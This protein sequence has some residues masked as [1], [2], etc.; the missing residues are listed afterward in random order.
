MRIL[1]KLWLT[2]VLTACSAASLLAQSTPII[3]DVTAQPP[4][5]TQALAPLGG[6]TF[7]LTVNGQNF[8]PFSKVFFGG[9]PLTTAFVSSIQLTATVPASLLQAPGNI[10]VTVVNTD[11][12]A[13]TPS[14]VTLSVSSSTAVGA[15]QVTISYNKNIVSLV[16]GN[17]TGGSGA[18]FTGSPVTINIDNANGQVTLNSF[19]TGNT[20]AGTFSV[21]NLTFTGVSAGSSGL[22]I[23]NP[24]L[25]DTLSHG[26]PI[27]PAQI[28]LSANSVN[29]G[30]AATVSNAINFRV[31]ER[32]DLNGDRKVSI[33]DALYSAL[34]SSGLVKPPAPISAGDL[35]LS[36]AANIGDALVLAL[37]SGRLIPNLPS[38][39]VTS[40]S[41]A[42]AVAGSNL[43]LTGTG[44]SSINA[45]NQVLFTT[46]TGTVRVTPTGAVTNISMTVTV[47]LDAV[48][49]PMQ[50][51]RVDATVATDEFPL[52]VSGTNTPLLLSSVTPF[53]RVITG[54]SVLLKG[55]GFSAAAAD[56][57]VTFR[58]TS[59][60][61]VTAAVT[62]ASTTSLT[63]ALP[64]TAAC[65]EVTVTVG[66]QTSNAR[67]ITVSGT[68]CPKK[69]TDILGGG[70]PGD[71]LALEGVGFDFQTPANNI[72]RF[73]AASGGTT[74]ATVLESGGTQLQ[75]LIPPNAASG[76]ITVTVAGTTSNTLNY[77]LSGPTLS[78]IDPAGGATGTIVN[79]TL[80][81]TGF[82][83]GGTAVAVSGTG[84]VVGTVT[85]ASPASLTTTFTIANDAAAG[86]RSV[87]VSTGGGTSSPV[88]FLI[89]S[90]QP[91][92][93][94]LTAIN[95][96][97]GFQGTSVPVT[98]TGT[99][100]IP[101][102]TTLT[103][104]GSGVIGTSVNVVS[105][106]SLTANFI[107]DPSAALGTRSIT[108]S[109]VSGTSGS[110]TFTVNPG[111]PSLSS[112]NPTSGNRGTSVAVTL[113]G[114]N[115]V[116]GVTT[117]TV[118]GSGVTGTSVN[119]TSGTSLTATL[120]IDSTADLGGHNVTVS[121]A[122]GSSG[123][124]LFAVNPPAPT[125][126]LINPASGAQG[127]A[128]PV[129]LG[130]TNFVAGATSV[131]ISGS[132]IIG[133]SVTV[134]SS[135]SMTAL[136]VI[137]AAAPTG[138]RSI[139]VTT[140]SGTSN[141]VAFT[142]NL[143]APT[144]SSINPSSGL[145]GTGVPITITGTNFVVGATTLT[146]SGTAVTGSAVNVTSGS[147]LT[148]TL[149]ID[150]AAA[151]GTRSVS[152]STASGT[153]SISFTVNPG[154]P[155]LASINPSSG[156]Q[157]TNI[158]VT[159]TGTNFVAGATTITIS[160]SGV[161]GAAVNV[162]G[163]TSLTA[164]LVIH[165]AASLGSH[166]VTVSTASGTSGTVTFTVNLGA[167]AITAINP[168]SGTQGTSVTVTLNGTNFV[169]GATSLTISSTDVTGS[170]VNVLSGTSLTA[171]F[172]ISQTAAPGS[173]S[174]TVN[175]LSGSSNSIIFTVVAQSPPSIYS[176]TP[177]SGVQGATLAV[178]IG[179]ANF[180][181]G[182]TTLTASGS[183]II[184]GSVV[185]TSSTSATALMVLSD[186]PGSYGLSASTFAGT[187]LQVATTTINANTLANANALSVT[188]FAG[189]PGSAGSTDGPASSARFEDPYH[190]WSDGAF[191]YVTD[192]T[193]SRIRRITLSTGDVV[194]F[195]GGTYGSLDGIGT[196]AQF[197]TP[198]GIWGDGIALYVAD[199]D[200]NTIRKITI[201]TAEVTALAGQAGQ[202]GTADGTGSAARFHDLLG[203]WGD[204]TFLYVTDQLNHTIRKIRLATGEVTTFA[205]A[206]GQSDYVDDVGPAARFSYPTAV[207][208]NG[209]FLYVAE[210]GNET[211]RR[212][213]LTTAQV[214]TV[215]GLAMQSGSADGAGAAARFNNPIG[216]W[217]DGTA[218]FIADAYGN[219]IRKIMLQTAAVTTVAGNP[220]FYGS[221]DGIASAAR[222]LFP[223]GVWGDGTYLYAVDSSNYTIRRMALATAPSLMAISPST[224]AQGSSVPVTI[225]GTN[226][227]SGAT[228]V[229]V[230]GTGVTGT[231]VSVASG[232]S[233]TATLVIAADAPL[234]SRSVYVTTAAGSGGITFTVTIPV[235]ALS[236]ISPSS[237]NQGSNVP[238][239]ITGANFVSGATTLS[240]SGSGVTGSSVNVLSGTSLTATLIIDAAAALGTRNITVSTASGTSN[241]ITFTVTA[242]P[243][244]S[245]VTPSSG[246][247]GATM[248]VTL[249]GSNFVSGATTVTASGTG[250]IAG[251][252][253]VTSATTA[254]A[255]LVLSAEPGT[256]ALSVSTAS[257]SSGTLPL[258]ITA[259]TLSN[260]P[261]LS[262][263][264][265][266]GTAF[267]FGYVDA[268]GTAARFGNP[269]RVWGDGT[270]LYVADSSNTIRR[271]V[272]ATGEVTTLAG[273]QFVAGFADGIGT[274]ATFN[275]PLGMWG[276]GKYLYI[277]DKN[278]AIIRRL[279]LSTLEVTTIAGQAGDYRNVNGIGTASRFV[280]PHDIWGDGSSLYVADAYDHTIRKINLATMEVTTFA[281]LSANYGSSDGTGS[282]ARFHN[283]QGLW[284]NRQYM[285]V[286][287]TENAIVRRINL[288]TAEVTAIA[289]LA[290]TTG[291]NDGIG[292][293]ARFMYPAGVWG[294]STA[295]FVSDSTGGVQTIRKV[296]LASNAVTTMAGSTNAT[297]Q[298]VDGIASDA[299]FWGPYGM[300]GNGTE[301]F[302][303]DS[304]AAS[305]RRMVLAPGPAL[306]SISPSSGGQGAAV[307]V[308]LTGS[309]FVSGA[310][311]ITVSGTGVTVTNTSVQNS[312]ALTASF[313]INQSA[314]T[315]D[316]SV[317]VSTAGGA[318]GTQTFTIYSN[319][320]F[321][322]SFNDADWTAT[323][324]T[325]GAGGTVTGAQ[326]SSGNPTPGRQVTNHINGG[327]GVM[328]G[329]HKYSAVTISPSEGAITS[330]DF[331]IDALFVSG[332]GQVGQ[333]IGFAIEQD[334]IAYRAGAS[335]TGVDNANWVTK[336][337]TVTSADF[338][339]FDGLSGSPD[340]STSGSPF[341]LGFRT[342]N[343]N[344]GSGGFNQKVNYDNF[345]VFVHR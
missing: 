98:L 325:T 296:M 291:T 342:G 297:L 7:T 156:L 202:F 75:V 327:T 13:V 233:L 163:V 222:F 94:T 235:A 302:V 193:N 121:T 231:S 158:Q 209:R 187:S 167:P 308:T 32:G 110:V 317:T 311:T 133:S 106:T 39:S 74:L 247:Q 300:W 111:A 139:T 191:L 69:L 40:V 329:F 272:T 295:L 161:T 2:L 228:T 62:T 78:A 241:S 137:D 71:I 204:G 246:I 118:S 43:T 44:Y 180:L 90:G 217:G 125:L 303:G 183:G 212:I 14:P 45:N 42:T 72:V 123:P 248:T 266:A 89:T 253:A 232:T 276:D 238:V 109:T 159:L 50:V 61:T 312:T 192:A 41:P 219:T 255:F 201:A 284:G 258:T 8:F 242:G 263:T 23:S 47:P 287:D 226:F 301:V 22:I 230:S 337:F 168:P 306:T 326:I 92:A 95:P 316:R 181:Q 322:Q 9:T 331:S 20:P 64:A 36:A 304:Q 315:G 79:V 97:S 160:G 82:A 146:I 103:V 96:S 83:A 196:A 88:V 143:G 166:D 270:Y 289:G 25:T 298:S 182:A 268:T 81:G 93:P 260:A 37:Y 60:S 108:V 224:G 189:A 239:T 251:N 165:P 262:V 328:Q 178:T 105:G 194:T 112:I 274:A 27:P 117:I 343:S 115:F 190:A 19:Q 120:V 244:I 188:T 225:T 51:Y 321:D 17:I 157:G 275:L 227:V 172:T 282:A 252:V 288:S 29:V 249:S 205:G 147:S 55:M 261:A 5:I 113:T 341:Y 211:I 184:I 324:F 207:W 220:S 338:T 280:G 114:T 229:T 76:P 52:A 179:G 213:D 10:P 84:V 290:N 218:L 318:S 11:P 281:G 34:I 15:Y 132:G 294:D 104:S 264:T 48:S 18:G 153:A 175:T 134:V 140:A 323:A 336:T 4:G 66:G 28:T 285:Y 345:Q 54:T 152:V 77:V 33:G 129:T 292:S 169:A 26:L 3:S 234:G 310:T 12:L 128:V 309:N 330:I 340:F 126:T 199:E 142:V 171:I 271:I 307:S 265:L 85:V 344:S 164:T 236:A 31:V 53:D 216:L 277:V 91:P 154:V 279:N 136:F 149:I 245:A 30:Q 151:V 293:G 6:T 145:Q 200:F 223:S 197:G 320:S 99:N 267:A 56:N 254:T 130:G 313:V 16:S 35:N 124:I 334:G 57:T 100:F 59:G 250:I 335:T 257:G 131:A 176:I 38:P 299:R 58:D 214:T 67:S 286:G 215:A 144:V 170:S 116:A 86:N 87:A 185:V 208:G 49:G 107:V 283:P 273:Q 195:A 127:T 256:Y 206:A 65:G 63:A 333:Q 102:A 210:Y 21:A 237:G 173:R 135:T 314:P 46:A 319:E 278:Y 259:N 101:G 1:L 70:A 203:M 177:N 141:S 122:A 243:S 24:V 269:Y 73:T 119:V 68:S 162:T 339:R 150:A 305:V 80:T 198:T 332:V 155:T 240:I 148:A 186:Q 138:S 174:V 221:T